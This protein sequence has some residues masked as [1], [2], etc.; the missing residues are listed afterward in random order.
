MQISSSFVWYLPIHVT[1]ENS[2]LT[3]LL[4]LYLLGRMLVRVDSASRTSVPVSIWPLPAPISVELL[5]ALV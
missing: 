4:L 3:F 1:N 2:P 5:E